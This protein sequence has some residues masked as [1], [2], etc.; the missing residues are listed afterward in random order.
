MLRQTQGLDDS[1]GGHLVLTTVLECDTGTLHFQA[2]LMLLK[3]TL[4]ARKHRSA[5]VYLAQK[6]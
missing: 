6:Y 2:R 3:V 4:D 1:Q 5:V